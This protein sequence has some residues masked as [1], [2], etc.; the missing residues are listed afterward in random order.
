[1]HQYV[2]IICYNYYRYNYWAVGFFYKLTAISEEL[3][4]PPE[5][6]S[7]ALPCSL[8]Q[9]LSHPVYSK[10]LLTDPVCIL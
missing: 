2:K 5:S 4:F 7:P 9:V 3:P 8:Q 10:D 1:M 6:N